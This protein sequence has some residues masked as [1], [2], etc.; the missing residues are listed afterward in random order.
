M[1]KRKQSTINPREITLQ[2]LRQ[3]PKAEH[4]KVLKITEI[5]RQADENV[6][7][8]E[9]GSKKAYLESTKDDEIIAE[10]TQ[11]SSDFLDETSGK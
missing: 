9:A 11:L 5:Y 1:F 10:A 4:D 2:F 3:A 7:I 8:V 6:A